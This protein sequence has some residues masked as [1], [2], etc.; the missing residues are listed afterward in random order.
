MADITPFYQIGE[1][2]RYKGLG[3]D[4]NP[5]NIG[6]Q[7]L[8]DGRWQIDPIMFGGTLPHQYDPSTGMY[9]ADN[10]TYQTYS[11]NMQK[12]F[13]T[14][15][16]GNDP[17]STIL[18]ALMM[19]GVGGIALSGAGAL[20]GGEAVSGGAL[21]ESYWSMQ[22]A[23]PGAT[24]DAAV[25]GAGTVGEG[26]GGLTDMIKNYLSNSLTPEGLARSAATQGLSSLMKSGGDSGGANGGGM[27]DLL[28]GWG[29]AEAE[30]ALNGVDNG[31]TGWGAAEATD[32]TS[33]WTEQNML[34]KIVQAIGPKMAAQLFG[35]TVQGLSSFLA[36]RAQQNAAGSANNMLMS[37]F[38]QNRAD[39]APYREA[40][41]GALGNLTNLTTPGKQFD[42][43]Q[44]DPGYQ[45]RFDEGQKALDNRLRAAG[46]F[47]SGG[48]LKAGQEYAQGIASNE[49]GNVFNRNAALAGI[50]QTA[51]NTGAQLGAQTGNSVAGNITGAGNARA[52]GYMGLGNAVQGG[53][54]SYNQATQ[55]DEL[56]KLLP[57]LTGK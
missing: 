25:T 11:N 30:D 41:Y 4:G 35:T 17:W 42:A 3:D 32:G 45:F 6:A 57:T 46:K 1:T 47:Y 26:S 28:T 5:L 48:A 44:L 52:S 51:T 49:F 14:Q 38:N 22:A 33:G 12:W 18:P 39:L 36:S 29:A 27:D 15:Q 54:N 13:D 9:I 34:E 23:G 50:G 19:A 24:T 43:M 8:P 40:G 20:G 10:D 7:Q 21:P 56:M 55:W 2:P 53:I 31:L 37:M 16:K